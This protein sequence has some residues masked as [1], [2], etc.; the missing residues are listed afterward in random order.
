MGCPISDFFQLRL[1]VPPKLTPDAV[2][3]GLR[4]SK[5]LSKEGFELK[6][7]DRS[8]ALVAVLVLSLSK[9]DGATE[10]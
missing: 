5:V 2:N 6:P 8:G 10:E 3:K 1:G 4:A 7:R 9:A